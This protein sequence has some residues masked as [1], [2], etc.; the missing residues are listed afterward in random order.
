MLIVGLLAACTPGHVTVDEPREAQAP[1]TAPHTTPVLPDLTA[2]DTGCPPG[3]WLFDAAAFHTVDIALSP[4]NQDRL[5]DEP[6]EWVPATVTVGGK[7]FDLAAVR[8]KGNGSFQPLDDKPSFRIDLD[9]Y[10][11]GQHIDGVDDLVLDNMSVDPSFVRAHTANGVYRAM[12]IPAARTTWVRVTEGDRTFVHLL[13]EDK[14]RTFLEGWYD[15]GDGS[16]Y[17]LFDA[18]F[19]EELVP[20][21]DHDGGPDDL[22]PFFALAAVLDTPGTRLSVDADHLLDVEQFARYFAVSGVIG[23]FD[24]YPFSIPGDDVFFYVD[25]SDGRIDTLPHGTDETFDDGLR[26]VD[27]TVGRLGQACLDDPTCEAWWADAVWETL[28]H[29]ESHTFDAV[30][31][32][33]ARLT[34]VGLPDCHEA[35]DWALHPPDPRGPVWDP[36]SEVP[37]HPDAEACE[38]LAAVARFVLNRRH[39]LEHMPGLPAE[40]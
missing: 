35:V 17:E 39:A 16:L 31:D 28:R 11:D 32:E 33:H 25:P 15:A 9:R 3:A 12:G 27:Y 38:P 34:A 20:F 6:R 19:E 13:S 2:P 37:V 8:L 1:S 23:Q 40:R 4:D 24:A 30:L 10:V 21:F 14:D 36:D 18:D 22:E 29:V 7:V 5:R 26:P